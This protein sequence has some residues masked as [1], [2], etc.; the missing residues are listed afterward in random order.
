MKKLIILIFCVLLALTFV[1]CRNDMAD[2]RDKDN[3]NNIL[4]NK[5][6]VGV[7]RENKQVITSVFVKKVDDYIV[8]IG[9]NNNIVRYK[10]RNNIIDRF[11]EINLIEGQR[12]RI[13]YIVNENGEREIID[14][15]RID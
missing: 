1:A 6:N 13:T 5:N 11:N 7:D 10:L 15:D 14:I 4:E 8:E 9:E 2:L 3:D 12:V